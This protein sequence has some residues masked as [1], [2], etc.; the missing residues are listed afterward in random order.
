MG[1]ILSPNLQEAT[2]SLCN[3]HR[4]YVLLAFKA[5]AAAAATATPPSSEF[6]EVQRHCKV[7]QEV[8]GG[9]IPKTYKNASPPRLMQPAA[10]SNPFTMCH[11]DSKWQLSYDRA[12]AQLTKTEKGAVPFRSFKSMAWNVLSNTAVSNAGWAQSA[13]WP[14]SPAARQ[15]SCSLAG[16]PKQKRPILWTRPDSGM[17][18]HT[19]KSW[20]SAALRNRPKRGPQQ[21]WVFPPSSGNSKWLKSGSWHNPH[22]DICKVK[23]P[24]KIN[25]IS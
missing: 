20:A 4:D 21:V 10:K 11:P 19:H 6:Q 13:E 2:R 18:R 7:C 23:G 3:C 24:C 14:T 15:K 22:K 5:T 8:G 9:Q 17:V 1:Y 12:F 16:F 25:A